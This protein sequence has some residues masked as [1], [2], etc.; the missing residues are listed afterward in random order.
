MAF[1][2]EKASPGAWAS[3][4]SGEL[5][6]RRFSS[7]FRNVGFLT[8]A[9]AWI[10][11]QPVENAPVPRE[12]P[13]YLRGFLDLR[14]TFQSTG[15]ESDNDTEE[16]LSLSFGEK[17]SR[18]ISGHVAGRFVQDLDGYD[19]S[20][21]FLSV[22][23]TF[24]RTHAW[25]TSAYLDL[26][27]RRRLLDTVRLG[28]Q[29]L[30]EVPEIVRMDGMR[31][32]TGVLERGLRSRVFCFAGVPEHLSESS[33]SR[34][35]VYGGGL[36]LRPF[37]GTRAS[38]SY[39][40]IKDVYEV[41]HVD[42]SSRQSARDDLVSLDLAQSLLHDR[43][44]LFGGYTNLNGR[45]R[46]LRLRASFESLSGRTGVSLSYRALFSTQEALSTELDPYFSVLRTYH[47]YHE[48]SISL[49][50]ELSDRFGAEGGFSFRRLER[51]E[52][53]GPFNHDFERYY[54]LLRSTDWPVE[55]SEASVVGNLYDTGSDRTWE[56]ELFFR[57]K[58]AE[59]LSLYAGTSYSLYKENRYTLEE[60]NDVRSVFIG[61]EYDILED[62]SFRSRYV[63]EDDDYD[64]THIVEVGL[65]IRF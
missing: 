51:K 16:F 27:P 48:F 43:L 25:L 47:P 39:A 50:R 22:P 49:R 26:N 8:L 63:L 53:V 2:R 61:G 59:S 18:W 36:E 7:L 38:I 31:L 1:R 20:D 56:T 32:K 11:A 44:S 17:K 21:S 34:D 15:S 52:D 65:R 28:R 46:D 19:E 35:R 4:V 33:R 41:D 60:E 64:T 57:Q 24:G 23:D 54:V 45:S 10:A 9:G 12:S 14:Y 13:W 5:R 58:V 42:R 37:A 40:R 55:G 3:H 29:W 6:K 30:A 62:L